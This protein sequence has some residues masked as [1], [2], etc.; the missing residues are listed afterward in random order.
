MRFLFDFHFERKAF[1]IKETSLKILGLQG[2]KKTSKRV[3][4]T[5]QEKGNCD[6]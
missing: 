4:A 2:Y 3:V 1:R 6:L 5:G